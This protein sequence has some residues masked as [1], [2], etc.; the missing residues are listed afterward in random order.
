MIIGTITAGHAL[1]PIGF[2]KSLLQAKKYDFVHHQGP[3]IPD[4]RN[5]VFERARFERQDLL[6]IDSDMVFTLKDVE[7]MEEHLKTKNVVTGLCVMSFPGNPPSIFEL[8]AGAYKPIDKFGPRIF[9]ID[10]CGAAFLGISIR[11]L[12]TLTEP[13]TPIQ[14][15]VTGQYYG[16]DISFCKKAKEAA[17]SIWCDPT[18][19]IGHIKTDVKY[20]KK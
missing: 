11:V 6:F 20:F 8:K 13:F 15:P 9:E 14:E 18:L 3:T 7:T 2:V 17:F 5:Q 1:V 16:E 19:N 12:D 10:G 4:N